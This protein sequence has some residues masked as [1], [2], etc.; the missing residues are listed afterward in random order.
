MEQPDSV[1]SAEG[2]PQDPT[3][4]D[5]QDVLPAPPVTADAAPPVD[6]PVRDQPSKPEEAAPADAYKRPGIKE[7]RSI[8]GLLRYAYARSGRFSIPL[9][10]RNAIAD[11]DSVVAGLRAQ[12]EDLASQ[13]PLLKVPIRILAAVD[14]AHGSLKFRRRCLT[15]VALAL[16]SNP[17]LRAVTGLDAALLYP[18][19]GQPAVLLGE[20]ASRLRSDEPRPRAS[21]EEAMKEADRK[22]L[23][24]NGV[25]AVALYFAIQ[26]DWTDAVLARHLEAVLWA[27]GYQ[28]ARGSKRESTKALLVEAAPGALGTVTQ[29]WRADIETAEERAATADRLRDHANEEREVAVGLQ[30]AAEAESERLRSLLSEREETIT[31]LRDAI[32]EEQRARHVQSSHAV[33]DYENLRTRVIRLMDRQLTLLEDGLHAL[34]NGSTW[35]TEEY[36]ERVIEAVVNQTNSLRDANA[37]E[38]DPK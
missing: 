23:T 31:Q 1:S 10:V 32:A 6:G 26:R 15:A 7:V 29:A 19:Y 16:L 18:D 14:R 21:H 38:G 27:E 25:L 33:D 11:E 9:T 24:D 37:P 22:E 36:L 34:R 2:S 12:I 13:D 4:P 5:P 20:V 35:V 8:D 30:H 28:A 3:K 17:S